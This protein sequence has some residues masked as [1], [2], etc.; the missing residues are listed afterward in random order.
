[1]ENIFLFKT[2]ENETTAYILD[3]IFKIGDVNF[4]NKITIIF[5]DIPAAGAE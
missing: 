5:G 1:L 3:R 4:F 2:A